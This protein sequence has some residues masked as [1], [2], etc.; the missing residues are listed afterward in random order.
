MT[1]ETK[2]PEQLAAEAAAAAQDAPA[3]APAPEVAADAAASQDPAAAASDAPPA[4][5]GEDEQ[6][7][8]LELQPGQTLA[9][10]RGIAAG[11]EDHPRTRSHH[12]HA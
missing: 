2:T 3:D 8:P 5:P 9:A 7:E 4:D 11:P 12:K 10:L 1:D 6:E